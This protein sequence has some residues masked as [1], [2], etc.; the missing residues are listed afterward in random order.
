MRCN[1][2]IKSIG[3]WRVHPKMPGRPVT[4]TPDDLL[5]ISDFLRHYNIPFF[6]E[7]LE[8]EH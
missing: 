4:T 8:I 7:W 3:E 1:L 6:I 2:W 5:G